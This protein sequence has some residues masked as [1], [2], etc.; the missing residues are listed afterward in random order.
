MSLIGNIIMNTFSAI[1]LLTV[2]LY[3][4]RSKSD[5]PHKLKMF[6]YLIIA[7]LCMLVLDSLGRFDGQDGSF[8]GILNRAG[9]LMLFSFIPVIPSL[10][11]LFVDS[12]LNQSYIINKKLIGFVAALNILNIGAVVISQYFGWIYTIDSNN[13]YHRGKYFYLST[14]LIIVLIIMALVNILTKFNRVE[15]KQFWIFQLF[16]IPPFVG[17]LLQNF[18][19]GYTFVMS[20]VTLSILML[21]L[22]IQNQ[23]MNIDYLTGVYNRRMLESLLVTKVDTSVRNKTFGA[24]MID[25]NNFKY[26]NDTYGH[27][28]GD[29]ALQITARLLKGCIR[30]KDFIARYGGDEFCIILDV[31]DNKSL[32]NVVS[33]IVQAIQKHNATSDSPYELGLSMGYSMYDIHSN[34][35][36]EEFQIK[37]DRLMYK[38]KN[39]CKDILI[40]PKKSRQKRKI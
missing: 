38:N 23:Y 20:G 36:A 27:K 6:S 2:Y 1:I 21:S 25:L 28:I 7:S 40:P 13:I 31:S 11:I 33:R 5:M 37:I 16:L 3:Y 24:I 39:L 4:Y 35:S 22:Y 26:I 15:K 34:M 17:I 12:Y 18:V 8:Y 10:W 14:V 19:Y 30:G 29:E 32:E 9:N